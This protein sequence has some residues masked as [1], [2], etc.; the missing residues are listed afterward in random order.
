MT[1]LARTSRKFPEMS[2]ANGSSKTPVEEKLPVVVRSLP[3][4]RGDHV[5]KHVKLLGKKTKICS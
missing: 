5:S 4:S 3:R 1:V 2:Q